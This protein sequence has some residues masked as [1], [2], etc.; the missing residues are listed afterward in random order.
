MQRLT[1]IHAN[2][3]PNLATNYLSS[4]YAP[5]VLVKSRIK[6]KAG[7]KLNAQSILTIKSPR[8][9]NNSVVC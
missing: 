1:T 8:I 2:K 6:F 7:V 3:G 4:A 9:E 5:L